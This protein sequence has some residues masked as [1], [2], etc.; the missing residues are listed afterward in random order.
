MNFSLNEDQR[1]LVAAIERLCEDFPIDYWR[2]HDE[3][4]VFPHAFHRAVA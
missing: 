1:S 4:A 2:D 3:R